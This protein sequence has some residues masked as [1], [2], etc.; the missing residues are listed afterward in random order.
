MI[1]TGEGRTHRVGPRQQ[2]GRGFLVLLVGCL[3]LL[4]GLPTRAAEP[5]TVTFS[6]DFPNSDPE[7]YSITVQSDGHARYECSAKISA[8]SDDRETYQ[9]EF[10]F[11]DATR[12]RIFDLAAQAHYFSG[13]IDSGNHKIAFTGAKKLVYQDGQR[14]SAAAYNFSPMPAVQQLTT[15][16]Q[17][18]GATLE[19]G[20]RLAHDHRYQKLALDDEMKR[21]EDQARRGDLIELQAIR[22]VLQ[23]IHD[24]PSVMNVVRA[25]AQ[26]I[27]EMGNAAPTAH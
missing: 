6:L 13:K 3:A 14:Q 18:V 20:R 2:F 7:R 23:E 11:S 22:P 5:A 27:I 10:I 1:G 19:F 4:C 21:I 26:R 8:D 12:A 24:D 15:L 9:T 16:F 25:R 17:S